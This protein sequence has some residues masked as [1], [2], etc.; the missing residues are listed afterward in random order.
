[1]RKQC[2]LH[3]ELSHD[4]RAARAERAA[5]REFAR[6]CGAAHEEQ[7]AHVDARHREQQR[8][9][10]HH[11]E[12]D[13]AEIAEYGFAK[14]VGRCADEVVLRMQ[15][16]HPIKEL[17]TRGGD[18]RPRREPRDGVER[19]VAKKRRS[20]RPVIGAGGIREARRRDADDG[21]AR[22]RERVE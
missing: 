22:A 20:R 1:M 3:Q 13:R 16:V 12:E 2:T 19:I 6:S 10:R 9:G 15:S 4:A 17:R 21:D 14:R 8:D 7:V 18:R 5:D 11:D